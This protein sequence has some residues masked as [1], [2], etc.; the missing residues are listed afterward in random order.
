[1]NERERAGSKLGASGSM[2]GGKQTPV[3]GQVFII[4]DD[5]NMLLCLENVL[6]WGQPIFEI[7]ACPQK[8]GQSRYPGE[9]DRMLKM[10]KVRSAVSFA[11][12]IELPWKY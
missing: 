7:L 5:F 8:W 6:I 3:W 12:F 4:L 2:R 1:M 11:D 10:R 9:R